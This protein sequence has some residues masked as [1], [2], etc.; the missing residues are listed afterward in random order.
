MVS[1]A[2]TGGHYKTDIIKGVGH[3]R[4]NSIMLLVLC[5]VAYN[6]QGISVVL[7]V[8]RDSVNLTRNR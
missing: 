6:I 7:Q 3:L 4:S 2:L 5:T 1:A 8:L